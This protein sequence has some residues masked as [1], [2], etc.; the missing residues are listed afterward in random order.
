MGYEVEVKFRSVDHAVL[1]QRLAEL[2]AELSGSAI[3]VDTYLTHPARDFAATNEAFRVRQVGNENRITYKG[4]RKPGPTKT[5]EEIEIRFADGA[6]AAGQLLQLFELLGFRPVATIRK[7][8]TS[9]HMK[10]EGLSLEVTL[11]RAESLGDF[12]EI[13]ALVP[14]EPDL[15]PAQAAVLALAA[16]LALTEV[17][18]R[19]YLRMI[20]ESKAGIAREPGPNPFAR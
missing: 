16:E 12:A 4:P 8:R 5:R 13:E 7:R 9:F 17:E 10:W 14:S 19:S 2:G 3:Q 1:E 15:R 11:D 18:P 20:L 6:L